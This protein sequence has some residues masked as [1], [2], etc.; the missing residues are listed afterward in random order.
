M[1]TK[2]LCPKCLK[3]TLALFE[4]LGQISCTHCGDVSLEDYIANSIPTMKDKKD[5]NRMMGQRIKKHGIKQEGKNLKKLIYGNGRSRRRNRY[6]VYAEKLIDSALSQVIA[7]G[8][9][10][11]I[12]GK[13][14][15]LFNL[16][17][18][19]G[20][21]KTKYIYGSGK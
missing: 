10:E 17:E 15:T 13:V 21:Y 12:K 6:R 19:T 3:G 14:Q 1:N 11:N 18:H 16:V 4:D 2:R 5:V 20:R 8:T 7:K 9:R